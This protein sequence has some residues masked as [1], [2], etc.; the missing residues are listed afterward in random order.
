MREALVCRHEDDIVLS[1]GIQ[2]YTMNINEYQICIYIYIS[3]KECIRSTLRIASNR[4]S[5]VSACIS[6]SYQSYGAPQ[7]SQWLSRH[8]KTTC[9][10]PTQNIPENRQVTPRYTKPIHYQSI[11]SPL[12]HPRT[13]ESPLHPVNYKTITLDSVYL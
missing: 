7:R 8:L 3:Y 2:G 9:Q 10:V 13:S 4:S 12:P 11:P 5:I 1:Q 6:Q